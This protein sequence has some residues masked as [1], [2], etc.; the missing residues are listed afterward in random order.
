MTCIRL[1]RIG[2]ALPRLA[3]FA[4]ETS[5]ALTLLLLLPTAAPKALAQDNHRNSEKTFADGYTPLV[6]DR[7]NT[8]AHFR[9]PEFPPFSKLPIIRPLPDPFQF[10]DGSW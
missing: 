2:P 1:M 5:L 4:V 9:A 3:T 6:Y 8:G 7:E 10:A